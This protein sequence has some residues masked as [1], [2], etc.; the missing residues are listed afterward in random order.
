MAWK[1]YCLKCPYY[2][3]FKVLNIVLGVSY[4]R[5]SCIKVKKCFHF[6]K[7]FP[8][9]LKR[10]SLFLQF[11]D[12]VSLNPSFTWAYSALIGQMAQSV[13]ICLPLRAC[14]KQ[15]AHCLNSIYCTLNRKYKH[16]LFIILTGCDSPE[17][18]GPNKLLSHLSSA[19]ILWILHWTHRESQSSVKWREYKKRLGLYCCGTVEKNEWSGNSP[20]A[21]LL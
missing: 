21:R 6:L 17:P 12:S 11:Q 19:R 2:S 16:L 15:Y 3:T 8:A 9:I 7:K 18:A 1:S 5:F 4:N 14:Q 20:Q 10:F 13:V